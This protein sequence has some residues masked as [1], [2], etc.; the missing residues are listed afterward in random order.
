MATTARQKVRS[1]A[2]SARK[3]TAKAA[4]GKERR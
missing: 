1:K 2:R 4:N 3:P